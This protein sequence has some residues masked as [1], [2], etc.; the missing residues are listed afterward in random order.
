[1]RLAQRQRRVAVEERDGV[2][3]DLVGGA[4]VEFEIAHRRRDVGAPLPHRL[5]GVARLQRG[6]L[7]RV[8]LDQ[9]AEPRQ[10][11]A[12]LERR[13]AA[14]SAPLR[15]RRGRPSRHGRHPPRPRR[16]PRRRPAR[17]TGR[18]T[19]MRSPDNAVDGLAADDLH[20]GAALRHSGRQ[21]RAHRTTLL[22]DSA[23]PV[24][25]LQVRTGQRRT[26]TDKQERAP[27]CQVLACGTLALA[28][29]N[30]LEYRAGP[31][32]AAKRTYP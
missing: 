31:S 17:R 13:H 10:A 21:M 30:R 32:P 27:P 18:P 15:R 22:W 2:A 6:K 20:E 23:V 25:M 1:M 29:L 26:C 8:L 9:Q 5:A 19:S 14:P 24:S 11:A 3:M 4:A 12:P 28:N 7:G 16:A